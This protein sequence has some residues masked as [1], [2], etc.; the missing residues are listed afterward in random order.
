M[1]DKTGMKKSA[2]SNL[3]KPLLAESLI[4]QVADEKDRR[5]KVLSLTETGTT[6]IQKTATLQNALES[7]W[8][9]T[10]TDIEQDLLESLLKKLLDSNRASQVRK[11]RSN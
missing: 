1:A 9:D 8:F 2:I 4:V 6:Y 10:L 3:L 11:N 7:E 5:S